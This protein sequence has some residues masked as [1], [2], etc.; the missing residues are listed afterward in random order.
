MLLHKN[1]KGTLTSEIRISRCSACG[2]ILQT[3]DPS[4]PGYISPKRL[5]STTDVGFCDRCYNLRHYNS[6]ES[7]TFGADYIKILKKAN[8]EK[9]LV[10]YMLD[11]FAF[12]GSLIPGIG[13][14]LGSNLLVILNKI[15]VMPK[16][17][18][19]DKIVS[20]ALRRLS[21][22]HIK[23]KAILVT[24]GSK[25]INLDSL[26]KKMNELR[27]GK[28][29]YFIGASSV[30]KS[31]MIN[32]IL[33]S[34]K[35]DTGR[36]IS[37]SR[38]EGTALD[39]MEIPLDETSSMYDTP[40]IFNS[41][42][43][44]NQIDRFA[45]KYIVP[46]EVVVPRVFASGSQQAFIFGGIAVFSIEE[47]VKSEYSFVFS[48]AISIT[49]TK[50]GNLEKTF[51]SLVKAQQAKPIS[52]NIRSIKDLDKKEIAIPASGKI[53]IRIFGFGSILLE[54]HN[55][56]L[57]LYVPHNVGVKVLAEDR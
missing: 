12:E 35:N 48:N 15:D 8:E 16:D 45:I 49:R 31:T 56:R 14:Y 50:N 6:S 9:A 42:S 33:R 54:G 18:E 53:Q 27:E 17:S 3:E 46:R 13:Q 21:L 39:V 4:A 41:A 7:P 51:D 1:N 37:T 5:E 2:A 19:N 20:E 22:D 57:S 32:S 40:G 43:L 52:E 23:P 30:G 55:Q 38:V 28:S 29:V 34:Y 47:G 24:S 11:L 26:F 25:N 36:V 10:V 44:L